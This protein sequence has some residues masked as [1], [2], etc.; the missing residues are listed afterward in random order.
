MISLA[1]LLSGS[2]Q[3]RTWW[4]DAWRARTKITVDTTDN[5]VSV[6]DP[7]G[8]ATVLV[9]LHDGNFNFAAAKEDGSDLRFVSADDKTLLASQI[10]KFDTVMNEGF[11]WVKI[12]D[13]KPGAAT[14]IYLYS[15]RD[16]KKKPAKGDKTDLPKSAYDSDTVTVYHFNEHGTPPGD[17]SGEGNRAETPGI[18]IEGSMIGNGIKLDG[19]KPIPQHRHLQP[20]GWSQCPAYRSR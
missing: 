16:E 7:I 4:S 8:T 12:P 14:D 13:L 11:V 10:E 20:K 6:T 3:A 2:L 18:P 9:R 1:M 15:A 17:S 19:K 5:G